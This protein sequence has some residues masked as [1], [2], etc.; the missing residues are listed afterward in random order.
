MK[1]RLILKSDELTVITE[2]GDIACIREAESI[3][4]EIPRTAV[5]DYYTSKV[6]QEGITSDNVF[7]VLAEGHMYCNDWSTLKFNNY[8]LVTEALSWLEPEVKNWE[9]VNNLFT[10]IFRPL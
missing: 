2:N 8:V 3:P 6:T 10:E 5:T 1:F 7:E 9:M 4:G